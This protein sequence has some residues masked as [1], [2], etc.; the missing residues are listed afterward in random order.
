M[1]PY[2]TVI[3]VVPLVAAVIVAAMPKERAGAA[4][5][6]ALLASL[7]SFVLTLVMAAQ[8]RVDGPRFQFVENHAWIPQFGVR[9][10]L[11]V[12]G[13]SLVLIG[14][15]AVLVPVAI[16]GAWS[17]KGARTDGSGK[18][19]F[20]LVLTLET[21]LVGAFAALDLFVFYVLFEA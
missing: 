13:I 19:S 3:G 6:L 4:K 12:D 2:L 21:A 5:W 8:F 14:L 15:T 16:A 20:A 17:E 10:A 11:G 7:V 1:F 9:Y 18:G